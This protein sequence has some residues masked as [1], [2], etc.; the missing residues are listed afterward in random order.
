[1]EMCAVA[2]LRKAFSLMRM[3][4]VR[5][6]RGCEPMGTDYGCGG[7]WL[8]VHGGG[9]RVG[10]LGPSGR[11]KSFDLWAGLSAVRVAIGPQGR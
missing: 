3:G 7:G 5:L 8:P 1:M 2:G 10:R 11:E 9:V 4:P 6:T